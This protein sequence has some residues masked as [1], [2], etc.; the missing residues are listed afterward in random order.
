MPAAAAAVEGL[1]LLF[2][3]LEPAVRAVLTNPEILVGTGSYLLIKPLLSR[4]GL[5]DLRKGAYRNSMVV[6]NILMAVFSAACFV[7]TTVALGWDH[8][9][10]D[11]LRRWAGDAAPAALYTN[12]CPP[13]VFQSWLFVAAAK[14]FYYS[15]YVEYLDTIWLV[16]KGKPVSFLQT[17]HHFGA[18]WDVYL[19]IQFANEGLWIFIFLNAFIHTVMYTYYAM[20]AAG[21]S[22]PAKPL[23]TLMQIS[24]RP[25]TDPPPPHPAVAARHARSARGCASPRPSQAHASARSQSRPSC[26]ARLH[27]RRLSWARRAAGPPPVPPSCARPGARARCRPVPVWLRLCMAV[28]VHWLLPGKPG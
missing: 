28:S 19:G 23:I 24:A 21:V 2:Q 20:T 13:P 7:A 3:P 1:A 14:A 5:V 15:K 4:S 6:Y 22:Y 8:G 11:G 9:Y 25:A 16:L 10:G 18:P 27:P 26:A 17:F 12:A